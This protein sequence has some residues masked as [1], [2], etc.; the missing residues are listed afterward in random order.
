MATVVLKID[1]DF[2]NLIRPLSQDEYLQLEAN[3]L[4]D[5]CREPITT[6]NG[7]IVD[8]HNRYEICKKHNIPFNVQPKEFDCREEVIIWICSNQLGRRNIS[9]ETRKYLIGKR[10]QNE[11]IIGGRNTTGS[12]QY[13]ANHT[14][15]DAE[16]PN[17]DRFRT[18]T[19]LA[20]EYHLSQ[21]TVQKYGMYSRALDVI[22]EVEPSLVPRI[23]S[24]SIKISHENVVALSKLNDDEI[25]TFGEKMREKNQPFTRFS[26][27]REDIP[28]RFR[29]QAPIVHTPPSSEVNALPENSVKTMPKYDPDSEITGLTLTIPSWVSSIDRAKTKADFSST[30]KPAKTKLV[31]ALKDLLGIIMELLTKIEEEE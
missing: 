8:G 3:L 4:L 16:M 26:G 24:G 25:K 22:G 30:S 7:I 11:K 23:L 18:A 5:G 1:E 31:G 12:N 20:E 15:G 27:A 14:D 17:D 28:N 9:D 6:W 2:K 29:R 13:T 10:Y 21:V 19:K